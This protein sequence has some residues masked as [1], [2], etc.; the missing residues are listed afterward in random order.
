MKRIII[1]SA[2]HFF[3]TINI[4]A[5]AVEYI[6]PSYDLERFKLTDKDKKQ[7]TVSDK[8]YT[9]SDK[10]KKH[11][12]VV[13]K[14][15]VWLPMTKNS[16][17]FG[18]IRNMLLPFYNPQTGSLDTL[19]FNNLKDLE[20]T[21]IHSLKNGE[22]LFMLNDRNIDDKIKASR[23]FI[24]KDSLCE[25]KVLNEESIKIDYFFQESNGNIWI[26]DN[27]N[28]QLFRR[29]QGEWNNFSGKQHNL[30]FNS[31]FWMFPSN[32]EPVFVIDKS[33]Y[34]LSG[35]NNFELIGS[36]GNQL[37]T[38]E[39]SDIDVTEY[40]GTKKSFYSY[41]NELGFSKLDYFKNT[42][43]L[44]HRLYI[45]KDKFLL[46]K[47]SNILEVFD[48][49]GTSLESTGSR[50]RTPMERPPYR[51]SRIENGE[52]IFRFNTQSIV[53]YN[54]EKGI[55]FNS[56]KNPILKKE[57]LVQVCITSTSRFLNSVDGKRVFE[58]KDNNDIITYDVKE[59]DYDKGQ[60]VRVND[61]VY[62]YNRN[63]DKPCYRLSEGKIEVLENIKYLH[64][65]N[66]LS[67]DTYYQ[68]F[69]IL[70]RTKSD[71]AILIKYTNNETVLYTYDNEINLS[72]Y[73]NDSDIPE[74]IKDIEISYPYS[75]FLTDKGLLRVSFKN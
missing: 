13:N 60:L 71:Y 30:K 44:S 48:M 25:I 64:A 61:Q 66:Y 65:Y 53:F 46:V 57:K 18:S 10:E 6:I 58:L 22:T 68:L 63:S 8:E 1:L 17:S 47:N 7:Y 75:Y 56:L 43:W 51:Y 26:L 19:V 23:L 34:K 16:N 15:F 12:F 72:N 49:Y 21:K 24:F 41:S 11:Y 37:L 9:V 14:D 33:L 69:R 32:D 5:Q 29:F 2:L 52:L 54:N 45:E 38:H 36:L 20:E 74:E 40:L 55:Y 28:N 73:L 39:Y 59:I 31:F 4:L 62:Y 50:G 67:Y 27:K 70:N 35:N 42:D 3:F